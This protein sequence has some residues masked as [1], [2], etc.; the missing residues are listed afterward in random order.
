[1]KTIFYIARW[2][3]TTR[4][5]TRSFLFSTFLLPVLF[6]LLITLPVYFITYEES[7]STK[8]I[9][10]INLGD[11]DLPEKLQNHLN[12]NYQ[13]KSG[14]PEYIILP[15]SVEN[16]T[17]YR[18]S[19]NEYQIVSRQ[20]DSLT[21]VYNDLKAMRE[22]YYQSSKISNKALMLQKSYD[23]LI[24]TRELKEMVEIDHDYYKQELDSVFSSQARLAAD[25]LLLKKI[26]NAYLIIP[27]NVYRIGNIEYHSL[28]PGELLD[29]ERMQKIINEVVIQSRLRDANI[30][31]AQISQWLKPL[32]LKKYQLRS[33]GPTEWDFY[34]EFYGAVIGVVLLFMAIFTSGGFLFSSVL[35][36]KTNRVIEILLSLCQQYTDHGR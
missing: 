33:Q 26:L 30:Q 3:F 7:V 1:M 23:E 35:S 8:L 22:K 12:N 21:I 17:R 9:G 20:F 24:K 27:D 16:S 25:S 2:E 4:F 29:A 19:Y 18:Q 6:S 28:N 11:D 10:I 36:E 31:S 5:K 34:I 13:L 14:S 15:V 32:R